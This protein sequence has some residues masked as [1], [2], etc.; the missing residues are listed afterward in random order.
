LPT[1]L[2]SS[3]RPLSTAASAANGSSPGEIAPAPLFPSAELRAW[4]DEAARRRQE[5][6]P[7]E[8]LFKTDTETGLY[9]AYLNRSAL[10]FERDFPVEPEPGDAASVDYA[11]RLASL[12]ADAGLLLDD[13]AFE[14][15]VVS[16]DPARIATLQ[17]AYIVGTL[18]LE[19][20]QHSAVAALI[21]SAYA[22]GFSRGLS[23]DRMPD[24]DTRAWEAGRAAINTDAIQK[25]RALLT[26]AQR[27]LYD[28][29]GW[30]RSLI[31]HLKAG[32]GLN[33]ATGSAR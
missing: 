7:G 29:L 4:R 6:K 19:P 31:F 5:I 10:E 11:A 17:T 15:A 24:G 2:L 3:P 33:Y 9:I 32:P 16:R 8:S 25:V 20:A 28:Q 26:P 14:S 27:S 21:T 13:G 30:D 18:G 22:D 1:P 23:L 12:E